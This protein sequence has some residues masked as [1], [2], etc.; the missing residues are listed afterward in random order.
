MDIKPQGVVEFLKTDPPHSAIYGLNGV[1]K[2]TLAGMTHDLK[3]VFIDCSDAGIRTLRKAPSSRIKV[4]RIRSVAQYLEAITWLCG[5]AHLFD[6]LVPDT[7]TGLQRLAIKETKGKGDMN[8]KKWGTVA[9]KVIEC[10]SE[11][12][13]FPKEVIYLAQE[14]RKSKEDENGSYI[15]IS[16]SITPSIREVLSGCVDWIGRMY[17][18][19]GHRKLTFILSEEVEAKDRSDLFPKV[20]VN[21]RYDKIRQRILESV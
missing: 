10:I 18:Q 21:P 11:T 19:D 14:R 4:I 9:S 6:L 5:K 8:Q 16:P 2:T 13:N 12:R 15:T 7:I 1:G 20:I 3:T 17:M